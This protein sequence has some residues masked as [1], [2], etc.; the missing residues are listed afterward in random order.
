MEID[1]INGLKTDE[2]FA[3]SKYQIKIHE[4]LIDIKLNPIEYPMI[5]KKRIINDAVKYLVYPFIVNRRVRKKNIKHITSQD[6]A[7]ILKLV[8]LEKTIITCHDIIPWVYDNERLPTTKLKMKGL[9]KADRMITVSEYSKKDI[10]KHM[11]YPENKISIVHP[12]VDHDIY[13]VKRDREI[14]TKLGIPNTS[15]VILYVGSEQPRKNVPFI[16]EALKQLKRKIPEIKFLKI[17]APQVS[18]AREKLLELIEMLSLQEEVIF[19][20]YVSEND[21]TKY[22]NAAD[23][24]VY[25]SL[26]EGF[27]MPPLEAMACG[28]PVVTSNVTSLPEVVADS[29]ITI[30][31]HNIDAFVNAMYD[32]LTDEKLRETMINKGLKRAQL[33]NWEKSA[34]EM[35]RVY[36][37]LNSNFL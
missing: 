32:V 20:G 10:I 33:F 3:M 17:G 16:L 11:G 25:P 5:S 28:T 21:I 19:V 8:K 34:K 7:Y 30:D 1:Y 15:K 12:A 31:P 4:R 23:L 22:Y 27:G 9:M 14:I 35:R 24:F 37:Q 6:L 36:E 29:A 13:Y 2:I 26:Y 18:G